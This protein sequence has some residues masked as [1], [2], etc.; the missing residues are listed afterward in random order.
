METVE[1]SGGTADA[2]NIKQVEFVCCP[3]H[4]RKSLAK[5]NDGDKPWLIAANDADHVELC[6]HKILKNLQKAFGA[7]FGEDFVIEVDQCHFDLVC[8]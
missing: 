1:A 2:N 5:Q 8:F 6:M 4:D 7:F 3:G